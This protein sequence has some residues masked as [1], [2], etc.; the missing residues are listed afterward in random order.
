M[1]T[2][3]SGPNNRCALIE[4]TWGA[5]S[6]NCVQNMKKKGKNSNL[7]QLFSDYS[8]FENVVGFFLGF[9]LDRVCGFPSNE[10]LV[11]PRDLGS[12][13]LCCPG[14]CASLLCGLFGRAHCNSPSLGLAFSPSSPVRSTLSLEIL[15][16]SSLY[17]L[18][19]W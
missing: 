11:I 12:D 1:N 7:V 3:K 14:R 16:P 5:K 17:T 15:G 2:G 19:L 6:S 4:S 10:L 9:T 13:C 18:N 8:C